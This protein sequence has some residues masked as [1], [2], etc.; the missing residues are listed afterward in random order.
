MR[1]IITPELGVSVADVFQLIR[2]FYAD[3][4]SE[5]SKSAP[6]AADAGHDQP[7]APEEPDGESNQ[8]GSNGGTNANSANGPTSNAR[9]LFDQIFLGCV[10]QWFV[11][12]PDVIVGDGKNGKAITLDEAEALSN[13]ANNAASSAVNDPNGEPA[14]AAKDQLRIRVTQ[15]RIWLALTGHS[16]DWSK[17]PRMEFQLLSIIASRRE[18]GIPQSELVRVSGQDKRSVPKRTD[19]LAAKCYIKKSL[20]FLPG[21]RTSQL[22]HKRYGNINRRTSKNAQSGPSA[23]I[24]GSTTSQ[25]KAG[26]GFD[27]K[28]LMKS[29]FS[30]LK[31]R[32]VITHSDLKFKLV[33]VNYNLLFCS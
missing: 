32:E 12:H 3:P 5:R 25:G 7:A 24:G 20:I 30:E 28:A 15:H 21:H 14:S 4:A 29:I 13:E 18:Q 33:S 23:W 11:S 31:E 26:E 17:C 27:G 19:A 8:D 1:L 6:A 2:D 22:V 9:Q 16:V 10:W